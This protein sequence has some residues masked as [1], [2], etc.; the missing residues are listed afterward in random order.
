MQVCTTGSLHRYAARQ[1]T[2]ATLLPAPRLQAQKRAPWRL[3]VQAQCSWQEGDARG[4]LKGQLQALLAALEAQQ[5]QQ[6]QQASASGSGGAAAAAGAGSAF[7][8]APASAG[9][10]TSVAARQEARRAEQLAVIVGLPSC[11]EVRS[12]LEG[13]EAA[14]KLRLA[15][16]A[17]VKAGKAAEAVAKYSEALQGECCF[18]AGSQPWHKVKLWLP[19][20]SGQH[21]SMAAITSTKRPTLV[22]QPPHVT[23]QLTCLSIL[24]LPTCSQ[25][26]VPSH[27]GG[28]AVQPRSRTPASQAARSGGQRTAE[29]DWGDVVQSLRH[30]LTLGRHVPVIPLPTIA[31]RM[32][33]P[34]SLHLH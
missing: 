31:P 25:R 8:P 12:L 30:N 11:E 4:G 20:C 29:I 13:L 17:A 16:N 19:V 15:G 18:G 2:L 21:S 33:P 5:A 6:A 3:W 34:P 22:G 14:D 10:S 24:P 28:A 23:C 32:L 7:F 9:A 1:S 27:H 26:A